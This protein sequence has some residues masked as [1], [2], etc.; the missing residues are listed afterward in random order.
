MSKVI[1]STNLGHLWDLIKQYADGAV[2][3]IASKLVPSGGTTGQVLAKASGTDWDLAWVN[4]S[5]GGG[6]PT[7]GGVTVRGA[8]VTIPR[9]T[10]TAQSTTVPVNGLGV[11][12]AHD[13]VLFFGADGYDIIPVGFSN[14][15]YLVHVSGA[16][17]NAF[18]AF[19]AIISPNYE[20]G[21]QASIVGS[22][23]SL[24]NT[25]TPLVGD[26]VTITATSG[27][28]FTV[29]DAASGGAYASSSTVAAGGTYSF[30]VE[31]ATSYIASFASGGGND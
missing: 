3:A 1:D 30:T 26:T 23:A 11:I 10:S 22:N 8:R 17:L 21:S 15:S 18:D 25:T 13:I 6:G 9:R 5:G 27:V 16:N 24:C 19:A 14:G 7:A 2:A 4:Q 12:D 20:V 31:C 29:Y 28:T